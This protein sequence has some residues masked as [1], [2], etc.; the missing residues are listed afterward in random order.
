KRIQVWDARTG[1]GIQT[2]HGQ[3]GGLAQM[4]FSPDGRR[5]AVAD[6]H[7]KGVKLFLWDGEK[8]SEL[9]TLGHGMPVGVVAY[10]PDGKFLASG[11]ENGFKLWDAESL[12]EVRTVRTSAQQLAFAPDSRTLFA[13]M[14]N[15]KPRRTHTFTR[16]DVLTWEQRPALSAELSVDREYA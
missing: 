3:A 4:S 14:T 15:A 9:R 12:E 7:G 10:S 5:L 8:L 13:A 2:L 11:D 1:K 16:W 6:W